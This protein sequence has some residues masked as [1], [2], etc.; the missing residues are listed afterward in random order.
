MSLAVTAFGE[1]PGFVL[2]HGL[3]GSGDNLRGLGRPFEDRFTMIYPDLPNHGDSPHSGQTDYGTMSAAVADT[4]DTLETRANGPFIVG[5]HSMGGKVA[6]R[7]ALDRPELVR[8]LVIL[9]MAP[10][11]YDP[12]H[13]E[14]IDAMLALPVDEV[15][16]RA[17]ADRRLAQAIP[18]KPVRSFLLKNLVK[19]DDETYRWRLDLPLLK[20]DYETILGWEGDGRYEGPALFIG[21]GDS[22]YVKPHRDRDLIHGYFPQARIGML[23]GAGHWIH[24]ERPEEVGRL[25]DD[26]LRA[27]DGSAS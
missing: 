12:S 4:L 6:M 24:S 16:S 2:L 15:E 20:R 5:G 9:D 17:D 14:I 25:I 3:F 13:Q 27:L 7:L 10:R 23:D 22:K 26:F 11:T 19:D 8:A 1:G 18:S 21:G